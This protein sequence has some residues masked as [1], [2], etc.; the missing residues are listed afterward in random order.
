[1]SPIRR[2]GSGKRKYFPAALQ[3]RRIR[4][5]GKPD[6]ALAQ[7]ADSLQYKGGSH[8]VARQHRLK[9]GTQVL[10]R[11]KTQWEWSHRKRE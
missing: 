2:Q 11:T 5:V 8:S 1:V 6:P 10:I 3:H 7:A 4:P 9:G